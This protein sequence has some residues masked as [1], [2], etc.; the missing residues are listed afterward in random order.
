MEITFIMVNPAYPSN[1]GAAARA[2]KAMGFNRLVVTNPVADLS[3]E[4]V[5]K[6]GKHADDIIDRIEV[7]SDLKSALAG[8]DIA[9]AASHR[10]RRTEQFVL[11]SRDLSSYLTDRSEFIH[12]AAI[13]VG[14]ESTGLS[15]SD[16]ELCDAVVQVPCANEQPSLNLAQAVMIIAYE[17]SCLPLRLSKK[18]QR[19]L[20]K[21][22]PTV[23]YQVLKTQIA[24]LFDHIGLNGD[25]P[26]R[27]KAIARLDALSTPDLHLALKIKQAIARKISAPR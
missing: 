1:I 15:N 8:I 26:L 21:D 7:F 2:L 12:R 19:R 9:I 6:L 4:R 10:V 20:N 3:N 5:R 27:A 23:S 18:Q 14:P 16:I 22:E 13:V 11:T 17:L 25:H 24:E